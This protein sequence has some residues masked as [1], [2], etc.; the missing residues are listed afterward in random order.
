VRERDWKYIVD[1]RDGTE[2]LYNLA[3]DPAEQHNVAPAEAG[4]SRALRQRLAAFAE[5]NRRQYQP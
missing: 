1:V 3:R 5:A 4:R 2:E